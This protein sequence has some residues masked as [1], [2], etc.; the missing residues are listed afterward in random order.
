MNRLVNIALVL[1]VLFSLL[2]TIYFA[3]TPN[4][5]MVIFLSSFGLLTL[6]VVALYLFDKKFVRGGL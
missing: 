1:V 6:S 2:L 3:F 4:V 5:N